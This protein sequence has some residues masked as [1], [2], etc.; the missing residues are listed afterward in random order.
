MLIWR[1]A[2][3]ATALAC[4]TAF[5]SAQNILTNPGFETGSLAGWT[6]SGFTTTND[7]NSG[8]WAAFSN[9]SFWVRQD[10]APVAA[11]LVTEVSVWS[12]QQNLSNYFYTFVLRYGDGSLDS[13]LPS[14]SSTGVFV[15]HDFTSSLDLSK[16]LAGIE[17][18]GYTTNNTNVD[19]TTHDDFVVNVVPEPAT[20]LVLLGG[21]A[22]AALRRR[23]KAI[24]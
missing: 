3:I 23:K 9:D 16:T 17:A 20:G 7:S 10:F 8:N 18:W 24:A 6:T 14:G 21:L 13:V 22:F 12:K 5:A 4:I 1:S 15:K 2:H 19:F 11:T